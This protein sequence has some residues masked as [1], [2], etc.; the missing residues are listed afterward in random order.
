MKVRSIQLTERKK[1]R[2]FK[3]L[4]VVICPNI[5]STS[6]TRDRSPPNAKSAYF[7]FL[8]EL[9]TEPLKPSVVSYIQLPPPGAELADSSP[10]VQHQQA[11]ETKE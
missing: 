9:G 8:D 4:T 1:I 11:G 7:F 3:K 6:H 2:I 10:P 5:H